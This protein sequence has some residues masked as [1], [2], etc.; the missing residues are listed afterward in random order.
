M[1]KESVYRMPFCLPKINN[2]AIFYNLFSWLFRKAYSYSED[3]MMWICKSLRYFF[4][5]PAFCYFLGEGKGKS[6]ECVYKCLMMVHFGIF[7]ELDVLQV[8]SEESQ[9]LSVS[10]ICYSQ[11][12]LQLILVSSW[13]LDGCQ[14]PEWPFASMFAFSWRKTQTQDPKP[15]LLT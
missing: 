15:F 14:E 4:I 2:G 6:L 10:L 12:W 13:L 9:I 8:I 11:V 7:W 3:M 1:T 5:S